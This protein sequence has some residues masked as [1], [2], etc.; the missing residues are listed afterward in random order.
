MEIKNNYIIYIGIF[1]IFA[2]SIFLF[3]RTRKK[4]AY[5]GGKKVVATIMNTSDPIYRKRWILY[6]VLSISFIATC[7]AGIISCFVVLARPYKVDTVTKK[8][9]CRD[10]ILTMDISTSVDELN[11]KLVDELK[12][13]VK[14]LAGERIGIV[15][16]NTTPVYLVPLTD[17]YEYVI[18]QLDIVK[19]ALVQRNTYNFNIF[20]NQW[21]DYFYYDQYIS[22]G[23]LIGC[24]TR[25][26]SLIGDGLAT[27]ALDFSELEEDKERTRIIIFSSDNELEGEPIV[28]LDEASDICKKNKVIVYGIGTKEM[29]DDNMVSMKKAVENTGGK[30]Y[31][32]EYNDTFSK[33]VNDIEKQSKSLIKGGTEL[34]E[35]D[36]IKFPFILMMSTIVLMFAILKLTRR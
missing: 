2:L 15:I 36:I 5:S 30:F 23:T 16:F 8:Q 11:Y 22:A 17:D 33:I 7:V 4:S 19:Q 1:V 26:S 10:I 32:E 6:R 28:T 29:F 12:D 24:E 13:T 14:E 27:A 20:D 18:E 3:I 21:E 31:L 25:G 35:T 34:R 9:Y